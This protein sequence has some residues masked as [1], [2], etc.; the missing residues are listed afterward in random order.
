[1]TRR[2]IIL[3]ALFFTVSAVNAQYPVRWVKHYFVNPG[4]DVTR[5]AA[6]NPATD[7]VLVASRYYGKGVFV[8]DAATG[9][10]LMMMDS[11]GI[12]EGTYTL[13]LVDVD[14]EGVI[15]A[16]NLL[17]PQYAAPGTPFKIYRYENEYASP[18]LIF[19]DVLD[20]ER[21]GD[22]FN[23]VGSGNNTYIYSSG[24]GNPRMAVIS[25]TGGAFTLDFYIDLPIAGN[26]R[27]G[28][29]PLS[30]GGKVW[31]N[32]ADN[33]SP[34]PSLLASNGSLIATV[35]D[36]IIS[37]GGSSTILH[38][39]LGQ[40]NIVSVLNAYSGTVSSSRYFEDEIGTVTFDYFG[41]NY[42]SNPEDT[43]ALYYKTG[44]QTNINASGTLSYDSKRNSLIVL[45]GW[46]SI[47]SLKLDSLVNASTPR[48]DFWTISIDG[49]LDFF[50]SDHVGT[51]NGRDMYLTWASGKFFVGVNGH[52]LVDPT[53][54]NRMYVAFDLDPEG[55]NGSNT[56]PQDAG[57]VQSL[58]FKADVVVMAEAWI[59]PDYLVGSIFKW[60]GASW[61]ES[62]YDGNIAAQ[63]ALAYA[64]EGD[65]KLAEIA[66][67]RN[68]A[69]IGTNYDDISVMVYVA[70]KG[71]D[72]DILSA[73]PGSNPTANGA[74]FGT[75][76]YIPELGSEMYPADTNYVKIRGD[77]STSIA[78]PVRNLPESY[79]LSANYPNPFNP[80][81]T[82]QLKLMKAA[83]VSVK[84]FDITGREVATL[85][86][87]KQ[88]AGAYNLEF[89]GTGL[90]SG[91]YF[92]SLQIDD[93]VEKTRKMVM[94]K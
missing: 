90:S 41:D 49:A 8:L 29:S 62:E 14:D 64:D 86:N 56:P 19:S 54:T 5:G 52:T 21:Y 38:M 42:F 60:N 18:E 91:L 71:S 73:F 20:G 53:E 32:G 67:I 59:E 81:T 55:D 48:D 10:S 84:V 63:G 93:K 77:V 85:L 16:C 1:M 72:G 70:E 35:P 68:E 26:A 22:A 92:Y 40:Y 76:Y 24:Q 82:I 87:G 88:T 58:P 15:Y 36:T 39:N 37:P 44:Q 12:N 30:P 47:A 43:T 65:R 2:L 57:G 4:S 50:P 74:E 23:V 94:I 9:D 6:Y 79:A 13:N 34:A 89:D 61:D 45:Y 7:H 33:G 83:D 25:N 51:S 80:V 3:A 75:Y 17:A 28:I 46:N 78:D 27:H 11:T 66:T 31:V 69:G